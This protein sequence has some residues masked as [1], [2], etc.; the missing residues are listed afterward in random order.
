MKKKYIIS[1]IVIGIMFLFVA[2]IGTGY[3]VWISTKKN[4]EKSSTTLN[5]FKVYFSNSGIIEMKNITPVVNEEGIE[6]SPYT[7]TITNICEDT[8]E[9]QVRLN[10]LKEST[11]DTTALT[12]VAAGNITADM[13]LYD[14][15]PNT[16]TTEEVAK[17][18]LIGLIKVKP[19]E[20]V[21]TNIKMWFDETKS[22]TITKED[23]FKAQ[24]EF[25]DTESSIKATFSETLLNT[26][27]NENPT[28]ETIATTKEGLYKIQEEKTSYY[29]RGAV[30]NNYVRFANLT[31]RIAGINADNT[32]KL[33]LDKPAGYQSYS[34]KSNAEDYTGLKYIY[35]NV[36]IN[37]DINTFLLNW[38]TMNIT[39]NQLDDYVANASFCNDTSYSTTNYHLYY[40]AYNR[41]VNN[42]Q[43]I[44]T[45]KER[46]ADYG[47]AYNQ[48]VGLLTADEVA[49]AGG[50]YNTPNNNYYLYNGETFLTLSPAEYYNYT[51]YMFIVDNT[52]AL[53]TG[54]TTM[55]YGIRPVINLKEEITVSGTG[56]I[57]DPYTID[58]E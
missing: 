53:N 5:C 56:T 17:S 13:T 14:N 50:V 32:I 15:L 34:T 9:L 37:N 41:L 19:N 29:Y 11:I 23:I 18:K 38:Y 57:N 47:G 33:I 8:K 10:V 39:N 3:G 58:I 54:K 46:T 20:T 48:K 31:W 1:L 22:P 2:A 16:K 45:C 51:A 28:Y 30:D 7:L 40:N 6:T 55:Q 43:P 25:I 35:N 21:R 12:I 24:F 52:G 36:E 4:N 49:I 42:K 44:T 26:Q 27:K